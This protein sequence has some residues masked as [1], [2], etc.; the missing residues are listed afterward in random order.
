MESYLERYFPKRTDRVT[1]YVTDKATYEIVLRWYSQI[2]WKDSVTD[3]LKGQKHAV[4]WIDLEQK[5]VA[6]YEELIP[7]SK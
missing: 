3:Y 5:S 6:K 4:M 1:L 7:D 2:N